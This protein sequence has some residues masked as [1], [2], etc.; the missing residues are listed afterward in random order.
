[1]DPALHFSRS[2]V[3]AREKFLAAARSRSPEVETHPLPGRSGAGG[4]ALAMD[5]VLVGAPEADGI[6]VLTSATH[7]V[8]GYCGS[9]AQIGLLHDDGFVRAAQVANVAVLF[10]HAV[11][12]HGFSH[13]R[14]VNEDNVDLNR[15]FRD[16]SKPLP[17]NDAYAEVHPMLLPATWPP[18][19]EN[20][21][22]IGAY[23][24]ARGVRAYQSAVT[25]GQYAF[26]D[27]L[28]YGGARPAWGNA[29][30]RAVLR[31]HASSRKRLGWIDYHTG[32]GPPGHGEKIHAGRDDAPDLD[33][34]RSWWGPE[35]TSFHDGSSS[36]A[37]VTGIVCGAAYDE[38]PAAEYAGIALEF[39]TVPVAE[40]LHALRGDHWFY[41]HPEAPMALRTAIRDAMRRA[42][43]VETDEWKG[44]VFAQA[45]AAALAAL[46]ALG[47]PAP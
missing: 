30:L 8:E 20:D 7:G 38:C 12:P 29:T 10:V 43:Y 35:V 21:A 9:G 18:S 44:R 19:P 40:V 28:F 46:S 32:L 33:R 42:F 1:M 24:A 39:G 26:P 37:L 11:N 31:R 36:S 16:F 17:V 5:A 13:G 3:E 15:N 4:E 22:A 34:A 23:V 41:N 47:Q 14:R 45:R 25:G 6:L 2:Y 27:G